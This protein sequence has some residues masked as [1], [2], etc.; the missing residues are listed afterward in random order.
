MQALKG[1]IPE[2]LWSFTITQSLSDDTLAPPG[3]H[4]MTGYFQHVPYELA[5]GSWDDESKRREL[6][7]RCL[8]HLRAYV[9]NLDEIMIDKVLFS[10]QDFEDQFYLTEATMHH[11]DLFPDQNFS[12][13][14]FAGYSDY[15]TPVK[16]LYLC[17]AGAFPGGVG[18]WGAGAQCSARDY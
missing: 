11:G 16:N 15:R 3:K 12:L 4:T 18:F 6:T 7:E 1:E 8:D 14:P 2:Q 13:R 9:T 17:G 5:E 10:P